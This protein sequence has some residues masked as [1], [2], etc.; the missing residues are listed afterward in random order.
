LNRDHPL[1]SVL[2]ILLV[3]HNNQRILNEFLSQQNQDQTKT[4]I[5][6][7]NDTLAMPG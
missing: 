2:H 6:V 5:A 3:V 4:T 7:L 1:L